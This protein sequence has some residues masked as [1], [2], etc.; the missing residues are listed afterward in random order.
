MRWLDGIT[1]S[2]DMNL[3][4]LQKIVRD[5]EAWRAAAHG[6]TKSRTWFGDWTTTKEPSKDY[7]G[8]GHAR[9]LLGGRTGQ[10]GAEI[11]GYPWPIWREKSVGCGLNSELGGCREKWSWDPG[12]APPLVSVLVP[13][14]TQSAL[15]PAVSIQNA[16]LLS[17]PQAPLCPNISDGS[18]FPLE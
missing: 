15:N 3:G 14:P 10:A 5:R 6:V 12:I 8:W 17:Q 13:G 9:G 7:K 4:R 1:D 18:S 2:T 16:P 11:Q